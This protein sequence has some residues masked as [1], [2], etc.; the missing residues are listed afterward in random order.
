[1]SNKNISFTITVFFAVTL[2]V[3]SGLTIAFSTNGAA[4]LEK[5]QASTQLLNDQPGDG[6][7]HGGHGDGHGQGP[8][9][10]VIPD[11]GRM[12]ERIGSFMGDKRGSFVSFEAYDGGFR[13][14]KL[15]STDNITLFEKVSVEDFKLFEENSH[16]A[17]YVL[18]G[19][20]AEI[21]IF[22]NP[23][24]LFKMELRPVES[25]RN[26]SFSLGDMTIQKEGTQRID[27]S[28]DSYERSASLVLIEP[29]KSEENF[30]E[31]QDG[32]IN[33]TLKEKTTFLFNIE[34]ENE[35]EREQFSNEFKGAIAEGKIG[36][37]FRVESANDQIKQMSVSYRDVNMMGQMKNE[38]TL[39]MMVS[40]ETLGKEGTVLTIDVSSS[41]MDIKS[42]EDINLKFDGKNAFL[43]DD[44]SDLESA[45]DP[46]YLI[47]VGEEG[48]QL[49]VRVPEFSTHSI[50]VEYL[51]GVTE[52]YLGS[53]VYY[54]PSA[55]L[56]IGLV[57]FGV[58]YRRDHDKKEKDDE[59]ENK[60]K[61]EKDNMVAIGANPRNYNRDKKNEKNIKSGEKEEK[62]E[63][64]IEK[65]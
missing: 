46:A 23:S 52:E 26:V 58:L 14:H 7:G 62:E 10:D 61:E 55:L 37:Q 44:F 38:R 15:E 36:G 16:G 31:I 12:R 43:A 29:V 27:F 35:Q 63:T 5:T 39:E 59:E 8:P 54:I 56:S 4:N 57:L 11:P 24:A 17:R 18:E 30:A 65:Y 20:G 64:R 6:D 3:L 25:K 1:M 45:D 9:E 34:S 32:H 60:E 19:D 41:V 22:D 28:F 13:D 51:E 48:A 21:E 2:I 47:M 49:L 50:T 53:L 42:A 33:Y 40:S